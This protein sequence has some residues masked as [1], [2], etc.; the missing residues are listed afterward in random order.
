MPAFVVLWVDRPEEPFFK[1]KAKP[2]FPAHID[3][4][5]PDT[6]HK[7]DKRTARDSSMWVVALDFACTNLNEPNQ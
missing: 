3:P 4:V 6:E 5:C 1:V 7:L 2:H